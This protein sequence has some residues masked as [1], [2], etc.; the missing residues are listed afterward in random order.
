MR[1]NASRK[2]PPPHSASVTTP[3]TDTMPSPVDAELSGSVV[4]ELRGRSLSS[5]F[6]W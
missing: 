3:L 6:H 2:E 4:A 1:Q 5:P